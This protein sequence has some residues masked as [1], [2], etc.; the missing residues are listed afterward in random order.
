M[1]LEQFESLPSLNY[2]ISRSCKQLRSAINRLLKVRLELQKSLNQMS[3][4][5]VSQMSRLSYESYRKK[6]CE[7]RGEK[8]RFQLFLDIWNI[9]VRIAKNVSLYNYINMLSYS[10]FFFLY[11]L[12][13]Y[14]FVQ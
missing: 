2:D 14:I 6:I 12:L 13:K 9:S 7:M 10:F 8:K 1:T 4:V 11:N 3:N 5:I